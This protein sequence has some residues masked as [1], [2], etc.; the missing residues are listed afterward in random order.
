MS[1]KPQAAKVRVVSFQPPKWQPVGEPTDRSGAVPLIAG[2]WRQGRL[3]RIVP[4][5]AQAKAKAS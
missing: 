2:E 1:N 3:A 4:V 5:K